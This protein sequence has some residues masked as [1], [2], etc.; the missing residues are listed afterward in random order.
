VYRTFL[1][2]RYLRARRTNWIGIVGIFVGVGAL[3]LILSIMSG[4]LQHSRDTI[5]G[6]L[7]DLVA[8]PLFLTRAD[9]RAVPTEPELALETIRADP[10]VAAACA[11]LTWYG[12]ITRP[13]RDAALSNMRLGDPETSNL[14]GAELYGIDVADEYATTKLRAALEAV[15]GVRTEED[16]RISVRGVGGPR[17][18]D[19]DDPFALP[20]DYRPGGRPLPSILIGEQLASAWFLSRGDE[21]EI[22]T[23]VA[24]PD[25]GEVAYNNKR[26]VV[27][28]TFRTGEN[29]VDLARVYM[30]RGV[31]S[32]FLGGERGY[33]QI[34]VRLEN[35]ARDGEA[36]KKRLREDLDRVGAIRGDS[37]A[38]AS[39][40]V[41]SWEEFR[42]SLLGA[43]E[44]EK[45]LMAIML[46]LVLVVAGFTVFAILSM[47]VTEKRRDIGILCAVGA[48]PKGV[49]DLFLMIAF[50][51]ALIGATFGAILG[52]WGAIKIDIIEQR[53]SN[54]IGKQIFNREVYLFD[55]IPSVVEP[56]WVA[57]IVLGAF[58]C[59]LAFAAIPALR[60][61]R[62]DPL[63]A[64]RYE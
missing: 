57:A 11:Q 58:T 13:G 20:P 19:V 63:T 14:S 39:R 41:R 38:F 61:A 52:V 5:R 2:W 42:G 33:S 4:F 43:I 26:F 50:W 12:I 6:S 9:G 22:G 45:T 18:A 8:S 34:L 25:T 17:V 16:G 51:D 59:A 30:Q 64:L 56:L 49:L 62:M 35:Y 54:L 46:S 7:S 40:E 28:G 1:S 44:N 32:G 48:T 53:L 55:H 24:D 37:P 15:A 3:I 29:E 31:L 21:V 27:A 23:A 60:A 36:V 10:G 47:M